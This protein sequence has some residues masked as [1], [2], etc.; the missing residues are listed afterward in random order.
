MDAPEAGD[1]ELINRPDAHVVVVQR[2]LVVVRSALGLP[3]HELAQLH[4]I[5]PP[6]RPRF[7]RLEKLDL[8]VLGDLFPAVRNDYA[9][10]CVF[11]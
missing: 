9:R 6:Q 5:L 1:V 7:D 8:F 4:D 11:L 2:D 10:P 3:G